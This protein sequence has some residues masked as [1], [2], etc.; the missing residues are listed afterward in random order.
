[1]R[2]LKHVASG[3]VACGLSCAMACGILDPE[4]GFEV[5]SLALQGGFLSFSVFL[6]NEV[7]FKA[8]WLLVVQ[9]G[10]QLDAAGCSL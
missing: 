6:S 2:A 4:P 9:Q 8:S 7:T 3:V 10:P 5:V 1:M